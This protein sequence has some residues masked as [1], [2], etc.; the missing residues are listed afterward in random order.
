MSV[1]VD[2]LPG[3]RHWLVHGESVL[4]ALLETFDLP[5]SLIVA[6]LIEGMERQVDVLDAPNDEFPHVLLRSFAKSAVCKLV[7]SKTLALAPARCNALKRANTGA[8]PR[9]KGREPYSVGFERYTYRERDGR[10]FHFDSTDTLPYWYTGALRVFADVGGEE[11]LDAADRWIVD[12]WGV[13]SNPW[14]WIDEPRQQRF[15]DHSLAAWP[16]H[17]ALPILERFRT[18]LEWHAIWCATGELMQ[19]RALARATED[20][21]DPFERWLSEDG[22]TAPPFWLADLRRM[23]PLEDRLW[24]RPQDDVDT[25]VENVG[26]DD[27]LAEF[28]LGS[29]DGMIVVRSSHE[30][31]SPHFMQS[32]RVETALVSPDTASAL[33]RALQTVNDSWD[34][35]I[36]LAG[37]DFEIDVPPYKLLGWLN[38]VQNDLGIDRRDPPRHGARNP[39][40][41]G[42]EDRDNP[43][44]KVCLQQSGEMD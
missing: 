18:Y 14:R 22:L 5:S 3:L 23:K 38:D 21:P 6:G 34:Y 8:V 9:R 28:G 35:R 11:F 7:E 29:D 24:S 25:W 44:S 37:D 36:P 10:R 43:Q 15:S 27:F 32:V 17:G 39:V 33:V 31:R 12:H 13:Q 1:I 26:D 16:S 19:V 4:P 2:Q 30:T 40:P 41:S 20:D 42:R